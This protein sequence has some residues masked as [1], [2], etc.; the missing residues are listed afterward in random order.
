[1][2]LPKSRH[3]VLAVS[4]LLIGALTWGIV[5]YPL[6]VLDAGGASPALATLAAYALAT[7]RGMLALPGAAYEMS[8][9]WRVL[10]P[11]ALFSG[12]AN[13]GF[14]IAVTGAEVVRVV[15]LFYLA[16]LWTAVLAFLVLRERLSAAGLAVM[17][18]AMLGA[19][20][21]LWR[22]ELGAPSP[23]NAYEWAGLAAG[24]F[25][26]LT[27]VLVRKAQAASV[28]AKGLAA[29]AGVVAVAFPAALVTQGAPGGW[30]P[31]IVANA[32]L[33]ATL[34]VVF[35]A[36]S[37]AIQHG[38]TM[39]PANRAAVIMLSELII[40]ALAAYV[41]AGET[42]RSA[43]AAGGA[44]IVAAGMASAFMTKPRV[45]PHIS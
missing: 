4:S 37:V 41:L 10:A 16:P 45:D 36:A 17:G 5:W 7:A 2:P 11:I 32:L 38:L 18:V 43:D 8:A 13:V 25:F 39:V 20:I 40:A 27:N 14:L 9:R 29:C 21:M 22:P 35:L 34:G 33:I 3:D 30:M 28:N 24:V 26:A 23:R 31:P 19:L 12:L 6:R 44:L 1:M 15:L 42:L